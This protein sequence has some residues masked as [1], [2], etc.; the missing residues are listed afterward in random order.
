MKELSLHILDVAK[1]S[2]RANATLIKIIVEENTEKN[3][4]KIIIED[5]GKGMSPEMVENVTNPFFTT[6]TTRKVGLG[7]PL[8]KEAAERCNGYMK[9]NSTEG[10]GTI[11]ECSFER[12]NIDRAPMGN[13]GD[14][15]MAMV[16]DLENS[17]LLYE[18]IF[19]DKK[20]VFDTVQIKE[21]LDG[22]DL[23]STEIMLWIKDYITEGMKEVQEEQTE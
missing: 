7:L 13:M 2:V 18:Y 21:I 14:T 20:F 15:M 11:V 8:L 12:E 9:I 17:E 6:R 19:N 4:I 23:K 16:N 3:Y 1:N 22:V 10:V 5:N